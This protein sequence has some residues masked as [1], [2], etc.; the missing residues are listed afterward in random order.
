MT[1]SM[2][3]LIARTREHQKALGEETMTLQELLEAAQQLSWQDQF[4]LATR[5]LQWAEPQIPAT[6]TVSRPKERTPDLHA[7]AF[8]MREDFDHPL[9]DSFWLGLAEKVIPSRE[10]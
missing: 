1:D 9:P 10:P 3:K 2:A 8:I 4:H 7:D 5:L 6:E